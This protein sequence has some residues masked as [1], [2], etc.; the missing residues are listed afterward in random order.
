MSTV[1]RSAGVQPSIGPSAVVLQSKSRTSWPV[2]P[3]PCGW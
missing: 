3:P 1:V 2:A